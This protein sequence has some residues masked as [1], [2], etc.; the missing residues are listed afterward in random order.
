MAIHTREWLVLDVPGSTNKAAD[1]VATTAWHL[2]RDVQDARPRLC[3]TASESGSAIALSTAHSWQQVLVGFADFRDAQ[4]LDDSGWRALLADHAEEPV[5]HQCGS[6]FRVPHQ[7]LPQLKWAACRLQWSHSALYCALVFTPA[8]GTRTGQRLYR[9]W[10]LQQAQDAQRHRTGSG[11]LFAWHYTV[12]SSGR[13][14]AQELSPGAQLVPRPLRALLFAINHIEYDIAQVEAH[15][16]R[17]VLQALRK[18]RLLFPQWVCC[19]A[20]IVA[21]AVP[22]CEV[23]AT[24]RRVAA[25]LGLPTLEIAEKPW[26]SEL[27]SAEAN[28]MLAGYRPSLAIPRDADNGYDDRNTLHRYGPRRLF[29]AQQ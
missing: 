26:T 16:V 29:A 12:D 1:R 9:A 20:L 25:E 13:G 7:A 8:H 24:F 21:D 3:V 28:L 6:V 10:T 17:L 15:V 27:A 5:H 18:D 4:T 2:V 19:S 11:W 14:C 22:Q 23:F